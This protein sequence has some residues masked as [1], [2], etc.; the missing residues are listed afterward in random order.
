MRKIV[1]DGYFRDL[2][3]DDLKKNTPELTKARAATWSLM[4]YLAKQKTDNLRRY[5][6]LLGEMP[7]D[8]ELDDR[9]LWETFARAFD[10]FDPAKKSVDEAKLTN[11]VAAPWQ[12]FVLRE[13]LESE[14]LVKQLQATLTEINTKEEGPQDGPKPPG[15]VNP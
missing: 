5:F 7:R 11:N 12:N 4:Y 13:T 1:T 8:L 2:S 14:D 6:Q 3:P 15:G 9:L 10:A